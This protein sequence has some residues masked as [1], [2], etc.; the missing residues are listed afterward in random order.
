MSRVKQAFS[1]PVPTQ[2]NE[3]GFPAYE[4]SLEER[5]VQML[6]TNTLGN[7]FYASGQRLLE[8]AGEMHASMIEA[9]PEFAA[10]A[11][12]YARKNGYMRTQPVFGL[13][14]L[15]ASNLSLFKKIFSDVILTPADLQDFFTILK[16]E[17]RGHG[18]RGIKSTVARWL[19]DNLSEYWAIKY[20]GRGRGYSLTDIVKLVHPKSEEKNALYQYLISGKV[21]ESL[22]QIKAY[23]ALKTSE[24]V[25]EQMELISEG[26]LP[27]EVVT[28]A[29][30]MSP[31][32]W[33]SL[34]RTMPTFALLR[35][36][37]TLERAGVLDKNREFIVSRLNDPEALTKS[38]ILPF[39]F[40][41]AY[42]V[43]G[44]K[45]W[46][47]DMLRN[48]IELTFQNLP[49]IPGRTAIFLDISGSMLGDPIRIASVA[50]FALF[51]KTGGH[52]LLWL[53]NT[54]VYDAVPSM[55]DS[56]LTQSERVCRRVGGG[57]SSDAPFK[58]LTTK[59]E[60]VDNIIVITDEQQNSGMPLYKR[61][62]KYQEKVNPD[63]KTFIVDISSYASASVPKS[64]KNVWYIYGWSD[65]V[66]QFISSSVQGYG[67]M[68][69]AI[70]EKQL[71]GPKRN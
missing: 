38:K 69:D 45:P 18:G 28:G 40:L 23:E 8:E 54:H 20:N 39:R 56:I 31:E 65:Q 41:D 11:L 35:N 68:V 4:R 57:T 44:D 32:L 51:K 63:V 5:Y 58:V 59:R 52:G 37:A 55:Y 62:K 50:S 14:K 43:L 61:L 33:D 48:S 19:N 26:K 15:S 6:L 53:F 12:V 7:T 16:S 49:E 24:N 1:V 47:K 30:K 67:S 36:L 66:L 13:V 29:T 25:R 27:H 21:D 71:W 46:V 42:R 34:V 22:K 64:A 10:K 2:K 17:G 60:N 3:D 9:D 70:K